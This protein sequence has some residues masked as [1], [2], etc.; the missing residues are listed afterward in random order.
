MSPWNIF[1]I[2]NFKRRKTKLFFL[3]GLIEV[4]SEVLKFV[5]V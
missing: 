3:D 4:L 5:P 2:L 1:K